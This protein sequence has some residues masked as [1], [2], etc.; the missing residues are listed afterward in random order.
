VDVRD[1]DRAH[2]ELG[3]PTVAEVP[4]A[5]R[6]PIRWVPHRK[7]EVVSAVRKGVLSCEQVCALYALSIEEFASWQR[8]IDM[9]GLAGLQI[10]RTQRGRRIR[11]RSTI[12]KVGKAAERPEDQG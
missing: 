7:A 5:P 9:F 1:D 2:S 3:L 6:F 10:N 11:A 8:G 4:P 12:H